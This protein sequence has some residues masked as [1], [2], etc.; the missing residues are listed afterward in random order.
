[1]ILC[2][3]L[4]QVDFL[5]ME[6]VRYSFLCIGTSYPVMGCL[7]WACHTMKAVEALSISATRMMG[8]PAVHIT[9]PIKMVAELQI[10][11]LLMVEVG[12]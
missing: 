3:N 10:L 7:L 6:E 9:Y 8:G 2:K 12:T 4:D 1:M 11:F 5:A